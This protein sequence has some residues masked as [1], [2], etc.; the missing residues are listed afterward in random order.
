MK[1]I[2]TILICL[3]VLNANAQETK[4]VLFIGNS[5]TYYNNLPLLIQ[6]L[7]TANGD[8]LIK[9]ENTPGGTSFNWHSTNA[10]TL[11]KIKAKDWDYVVMQDQSQIP[12]FSPGQVATDS[13]PY[14][15]ILCDSI[16]A[17]N[18]CTKAMFYMTWG[19]EYGDAS[20]CG[21]YPPICTYDGMQQRLRESYL[22]MTTENEAE[23]APVGMAW[24]KV[25]EDF[26]VIN[27]YAGDSSHPSLEGSYLAACVI[28]TSMFHKSTVGVSFISTLDST[29]AF[30]LQTIA[31][32]TVLDSLD[33]WQIDTNAVL[34]N[35]V[36]S[37]ISACD[38][39]EVNGNWFYSD[40]AF[41]DTTFINAPCDVVIVNYTINIHKGIAKI[42]NFEQ[43]LPAKTA[44]LGIYF[45][46]Y[47]ENFYSLVL[48]N[49]DTIV[50]V[51]NENP[52]GYTYFC[53]ENVEQNLTFT[54]VA[55]NSCGSDSATEFFLCSSLGG[56]I[57]DLNTNNWKISPN[58]TNNFIDIVSSNNENFTTS[59]FDISGREVILKTKETILDLSSL[60]KGM[61]FVVLYNE[62]GLAIGQKRIIKN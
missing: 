21:A 7:A 9:D 6:N 33:V 48:Y 15:K 57:G 47:A 35:V 59:L 20:N 54:L 60:D 37:V 27:L 52:N 44:E 32:A 25:R 43:Y 13:K 2:I 53:G 16:K 56:A 51:F 26:P 41:S 42:L 62:E 4:K 8:V 28:Y 5:Y 36:D 11:S 23:C 10:N 22:E 18:A 49:N 1:K 38:S 61:Y 46:L 19:R 39:T 24:K 58:P 30:R 12:S 3:F 55:V 50:A 40:T 14:A 31:S 29:T 34:P 17:N 45:G